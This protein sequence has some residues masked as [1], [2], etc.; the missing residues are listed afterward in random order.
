MSSGRNDIRLIELKD[1]ISQLNQTI[2]VQ[3]EM[4]K[5]L[6][7]T[8]EEHHASDEKK[9]QIISNL[10]AEIS[11]LKAKLFG[12]SSE[13]RR[14]EDLPGQMSL[15]DELMEEEPAKEIE[16]E[17]IEIKA[18]ERKRKKKPD[19]NEQFRD[20]PVR[21]E[22][23]DTLTEEQKT[24][25]ICGTKMVEIGHEL[26]RSEVIFTPAKLERVEYIATTYGCPKCKETEEPQFVKD[27]GVPALLRGSYVSPSL[28]A[29]VIC[30][31]FMNAMPLY[32]QE[33][34]WE[35][36]G[37]T[38]TRASMARWIIHC[39]KTYFQPMYEYFEKQLKKR[40]F[41]MMDETRLQVLKEEWRRAQTQSFIWVVRSGED[42]LPKI[43]LYHYTETR[44][45]KHA[46]GFLDGIK[47]GY[48]F[49]ADGC[50]GY[51]LLKDGKRCCCYAHIRRYL[52]EAI[53]KGHEKDYTDPAVQGVLY[54]D[55]LFEY[56][57]RYREKGFSPEQKKKRRLKDEKPVIEAFLSWLDAQTPVKGSRLDQAVIYIRNRK[58]SLMTYLEDGRCSLSN[59]LSE[60]AIRPITVGRKN[61]LFCDS[62]DGA[63][64]SAICFTMIE[65]AKA[66]DLNVYKYLN[67]LLE[68]RPNARTAQKELEKLAP[69]NEEVQKMFA[70]KMK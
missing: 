10:Q 33:K 54:C 58:D 67:F 39:S 69:W 1:T 46:V 60:N 50:R 23:V 61:W 18:H 59:N 19:L 38:I 42:G 28:A 45:G 63:N 44:A 26:I 7:K 15:F 27:N 68:K 13:K 36:L 22:F 47:P 40:K 11:Y 29:H 56:E 8:I 16:P 31:K 70:R 53:P 37:A 20:I 14:K 25:S 24:C 4:I 9:D 6:R 21:Q 66:Y 64:A 41:L 43:V 34:D 57:R 49:M 52:L 17:Y 35:Q 51:N 65:M 32:R 5:D 3:T 2:R 62:V 12:A 30:Q 55:K 48:Y